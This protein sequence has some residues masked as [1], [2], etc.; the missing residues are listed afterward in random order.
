MIN[1]IGLCGFARSGK[2]S[3]ANFILEE[4]ESGFPQK[5]ETLSFAYAL[6]KELEPF[7]SSKLG[8]STF[9]EDPKEKEIIRPLLVC[10]G[11]EVIRKQIDKD[12]WVKAVKKMAQTNRKNQI[13]SIITD[14]RFENEI[15]WIKEERGVSIFIER[16]NV[17]PKN[18]DELHHTLPLKE[19]CDLTFTWPTLKNFNTE[20]R[21]LALRFLKENNLCHLITATKNL[22]TT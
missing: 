5:T 20:G 14:V 6:R 3:F 16:K 19:K 8:I 12:Y 11:T 22:Q 13:T 4:Q 2:N 9:T 1:L 21:G 15:D 10:W 7:V 17:G 18:A